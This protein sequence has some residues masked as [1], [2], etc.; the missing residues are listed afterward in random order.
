MDPTSASKESGRALPLLHGKRLV[1]RK[2]QPAHLA[3]RV[4]GI[5]VDVGHYSKRTGCRGGCQVGEVAV[6]ELGRPPSRSAGRRRLPEVWRW[7]RHAEGR[8]SGVYMFITPMKSAARPSRRKPT[9][10]VRAVT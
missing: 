2:V 4:E 1:V 5:Q 3:L 8:E 9:R 7:R 6:G 10:A